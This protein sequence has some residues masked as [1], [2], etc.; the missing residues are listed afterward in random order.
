MFSC[1]LANMLFCF[2]LGNTTVVA[3]KRF[4]WHFV[5][6]HLPICELHPQHAHTPLYSFLFDIRHLGMY[7]LLD[8]HR[9]WIGL[10]WILYRI[11]PTNLTEKALL[12]GDAKGVFFSLSRTF[13]VRIRYTR[14]GLALRAVFT[15]SELVCTIASKIRLTRAILES[16]SEYPKSL[17]CR[18]G[19]LRLTGGTGPVNL[20]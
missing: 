8:T 12:Q 10:R 15:Y 16:C 17:H 2:L 11:M 13:E 14:Q 6:Y 18:P 5:I 1:S 7:L 9:H 4:I 19:W 20:C 3:K